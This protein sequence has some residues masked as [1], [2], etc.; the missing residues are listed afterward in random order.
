MSPL[1][2]RFLPASIGE[3][4]HIESFAVHGRAGFAGHCRRFLTGIS[5]LI[6]ASRTSRFF[7]GVLSSYLTRG[8]TVVI[9]FFITPFVLRHI[10]QEN[11]GIWVSIGQ[12]TGY[13]G[14]LDLGFTGSARILISR[15]HHEKGGDTL[16]SVFS[17]TILF[18]TLIAFLT[19]A[20]GSAVSYY[21]PGFFRISSDASALVWKTALLAAVAFSISFPIRTFKAVLGGTQHVA[22]Q[23]WTELANYLLQ[24][25][26]LIALLTTGSGLLAL[27]LAAI[28]ANTG[29]LL[30]FYLA[31]KSRVP[32][33]GFRLSLVRR[34]AIKYIF[35]LSFWWLLSSLGILLIGA[36]DYLVIG[37]ILGPGL[38]TVYAL[39]YRLAGLGRT[40]IYEITGGLMPGVGDLIGRREMEKLKRIFLLSF[41]V[42]LGLG[43]SLAVFLLLFN[44]H[45]IRFWVGEH[46]F[47]GQGITLV[48][49]LAIF[50]MIVSN[51]CAS[52]ISSFLKLK[53]L[54]VVRWSEGLINLSLSIY[55]A[56][57]IGLI[58]VALGTL[59]A[60]LLTSSWYFPRKISRILS[61]TAADLSKSL[62]LPLL[63]F[64]LFLFPLAVLLTN[65]SND[66]LLAL[67]LNIAVFSFSTL[68]AGY[69]I[70]LSPRDKEHFRLREKRIKSP[71]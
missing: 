49:A 38:V 2:F 27:P 64:S 21:V 15:S 1:A 6:R 50:Q 52:F 13:F 60:G 69:L 11:Y 68:L 54:A 35:S 10:G 31:S 14:T 39:T 62:A 48:F 45:I 33:L 29:A 47:A 65:I 57:E 43:L 4:G 66:S 16:N 20:A 67:L 24:T 3:P 8:I 32:T 71:S 26:A 70:L 46:N 55:L 40:Q 12:I 41:K 58:G 42:I 19:L 37:R 56:R 51:H 63:R 9:G 25:I 5:C 30:L 53:S 18:H 59:I 23:K 36:T 7:H 22:T 44:R 28:L 61:L 17:I 34:D